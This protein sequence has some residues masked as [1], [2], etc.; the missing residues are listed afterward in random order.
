MQT[1]QCADLSV[2]MERDD[3]P[4]TKLLVF[5]GPMWCLCENVIRNGFQEI[6]LCV[7]CCTHFN[8]PSFEAVTRQSKFMS[9]KCCLET[10]WRC[11]CPTFH[12]ARRTKQKKGIL[13]QSKC[14][15]RRLNTWA[16]MDEK[17]FDRI[18]L[19]KLGSSELLTFWL[20]CV[21]RPPPTHVSHT[22][23]TLSFNPEP[24]MRLRNTSIDGPGGG[25]LFE[26]TSG[27][28]T[29]GQTRCGL[30]SPGWTSHCHVNIKSHCILNI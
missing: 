14:A 13:K 25:Q 8:R 5:V 18:S 24:A 9:E 3:S 10:Q 2:L 27:P 11:T 20:C 22:S 15:W 4:N 7:S 17:K 26:D 30:G 29:G 12:L 16:V 28:D 6:P 19:H 21:H 23:T 1:C